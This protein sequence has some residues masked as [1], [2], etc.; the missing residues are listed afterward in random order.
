[1]R[2]PLPPSVQDRIHLAEQPVVAKPAATIAV[3]RDGSEGLEVFLMRRQRSM[4]FAAGMYVFPGGGVHEEDA[5]PISW[6][7][8]TPEFFAQ[9]FGCGTELAHGLVVAAARETFEET[10]VLL[11]G[12][13]EQ[14]IVPDATEFHDARRSLE[15][16]D[17]SFREFLHQHGLTLRADL[18][19]SWSHWITPAFEPRRYDT[20]FFVARLPNGQQIDWVNGEADHSLWAPLGQVLYQVERGEVSMLPPTAVTC[21]ELSRETITSVLATAADRIIRPI[22]PKIVEVDGAHWLEVGNADEI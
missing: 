9:R 22:E 14:T 17:I 16:R 4:A 15:Q 1:M 12:V 10:G 6:V 19:G 2:I 8:P 3:V 18:L 13:D 21:R 7:G 11:A 20:R 5:E